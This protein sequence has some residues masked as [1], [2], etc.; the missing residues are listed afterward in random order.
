MQVET[1]KG[2]HYCV[3]SF[4]GITLDRQVNQLR[5]DISIAPEMPEE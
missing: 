4:T 5:K 1:P 2:Q 3:R